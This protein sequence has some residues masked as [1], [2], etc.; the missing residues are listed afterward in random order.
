VRKKMVTEFPCLV[1]Q[2]IV[3]RSSSL[4]KKKMQIWSKADELGSFSCKCG[5]SEQQEMENPEE[6]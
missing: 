3:F 1:E 4:K 2:H 6:I 5:A